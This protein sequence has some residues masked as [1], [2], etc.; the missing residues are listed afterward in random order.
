MSTIN[1]KSSAK[2]SALTKLKALEDERSK[3]ISLRKSEIL[4]HFET[5][6]ALSV[7][8]ALLVGFL[9][10]VMNDVNKNH[11]MLSEFRSLAMTTKTPSRTK[12]QNI[13]TA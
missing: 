1:K 3:L 7:D 8:D 2:S 10:F 4:K 13:E 9:R 6:S 11:P 12:Q 5:N